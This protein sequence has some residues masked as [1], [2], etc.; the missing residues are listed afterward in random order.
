MTRRDPSLHRKPIGRAEAVGLAFASPWL[1]G[2]LVL[3]L[4]PI[5]A[6]IYFSVCRYNIIRP[7]HFIGLENYRLLISEDPLF[8]KSLWNTLYL[9]AFGLPLQLAFALLAA[10]LLNAK[11]RGQSVFRTFIYLPA[12][13]PAVATAILWVWLLNPEY[14]LVN[15]GLNA[16]GLRGPG[17]LTD[18]AW[19]KPALIL[20]MIW[21][22]GNTMV[23]FLAGLQQVPRVL[24]EASLIDGAN[25]IQRFWNVTVPM[26][27][28]VIFFNL[29]MGI[30][31][32]FQYF[33][34]VYVMTAGLMG[35]GRGAGGPEFSTLVYP[36][37]LYQNAFLF[38]RMGYASAMAWILFVIVA[39]ILVGVFRTSRWVYYEKS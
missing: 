12:V 33:T 4:Y 31:G 35:G 32:S 13:V 5:L 29:V 11:V 37:Y 6:S 3:G 39:A 14:G 16:L 17:W 26:I 22:V 10:M 8:W 24:Y 23:I 2:L 18:P 30:I 21:G 20:V 28:P 9:T 1:L 19:S 25:G 15:A 7:P 36:L 38:F 27:S 34:H